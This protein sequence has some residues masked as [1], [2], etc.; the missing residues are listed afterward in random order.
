MIQRSQKIVKYY[1]ELVENWHND[2]NCDNSLEYQNNLRL[3]WFSALSSLND[4]EID[5][6]Y[7][8]PHVVD[9]IKIIVD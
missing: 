7:K 3:V 5:R 6:L 9:I 8:L 4:K 2:I 1:R